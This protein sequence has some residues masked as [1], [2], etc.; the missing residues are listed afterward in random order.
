MCFC[1]VVWE[2]LWLFLHPWFSRLPFRQWGMS[3]PLLVFC[4]MTV[5]WN[6][7]KRPVRN[8]VLPSL[9]F[10]IVGITPSNFHF[11]LYL[12]YMLICTQAEMLSLW[13]F[14]LFF[15]IVIAQSAGMYGILLEFIQKYLISAL[16]VPR[17]VL[18]A[19]NAKMNRIRSLPWRTLAQWAN[20]YRNC[21]TASGE[22]L[23]WM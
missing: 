23:L 4:E 15:C 3:A 6:C 18:E 20:N 11:S 21:S 14:Y 1:I 19:G 22:N 2:S 12:C 16:C 17:I 5:A 8:G 9:I 7:Y 13:Y 10:R